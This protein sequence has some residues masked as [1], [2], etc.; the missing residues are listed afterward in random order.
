M[1]HVPFDYHFY[2]SCPHSFA[3]LF[4]V[5]FYDNN[6][7]RGNCDTL[8]KEFV[9]SVLSDDRIPLHQDS[10]LDHTLLKISI[11]RYNKFSYTEKGKLE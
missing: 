5:V 1:S 6:A 11:H 8:V 4:I 2:D 10:Y 7:L 3:A 9:N